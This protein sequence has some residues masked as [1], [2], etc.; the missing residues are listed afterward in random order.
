MSDYQ[1]TR[2]SDKKIFSNIYIIY[3]LGIA[4]AVRI[5]KNN[6]E[7]CRISLNYKNKNK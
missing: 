3:Q 1:I 5:K 6:I 4:L 7:A 2:K